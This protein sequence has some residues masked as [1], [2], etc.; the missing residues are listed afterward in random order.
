MTA[1]TS[2]LRGI[3]IVGCG[4]V[5]REHHRA[6]IATAGGTVV[7]VADPDRGAAERLAAAAGGATVHA[8]L[9]AL[10]ADERVSVVGVCTPPAL[11]REVAA[12]AL[13]SG[14]DVLIEKPLALT[15]P[16]CDE[17]IAAR[18]RSGCTAAVGFNLRH[19]PIV[20]AARTTIAAG[21]IGA[22]RALSHSWIGPAHGA[23][24]WSSDPASGGSLAMERGSHCLDLARFLTG[25]ELE[26]VAAGGD[27]RPG[28]LA[29]TLT[30]ADD[31][32]IASIV[33][34]NAPAPANEI[35][36]IG[37]SGS[38]EL[39]LY[40]FD[41]LV[42]REGGELHSTPGAR[43]RAA[44]RAPLK[45]PA[46]FGALRRGGVFRD[47]YAEQ[48]RAFG[49]AA[50]GGTPGALATLEDGRRAVELALDLAGRTGIAEPGGR[51]AEAGR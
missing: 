39:D 50:D 43:A 17:I 31:Q 2:P 20:A 8:S 10:L 14:R 30:L 40:A 13:T 22:L 47:S 24:A 27:A 45:L 36:C 42:P 11:H 1:R 6:A 33:M 41:G 15:V 51:V 46:A 16:D 29:L 34:A 35:R 23:G 19:H 26:L 25:A 12:A 49:R 48:W 28:P 9:D 7:A 32:L 18:D 5:A 44:L 21:E 3:G 4:Y 37:D 38:L